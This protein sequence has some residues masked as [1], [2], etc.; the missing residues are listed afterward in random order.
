VGFG[1]RQ[2]WIYYQKSLAWMQES[3][4]GPVQEAP[5]GGAEDL[6]LAGEDLLAIGVGSDGNDGRLW[7]ML[8]RRPSG[9]AA[10]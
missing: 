2:V 9:T 4:F 5:V 3:G 7:R 6:Q 8:A 10:R 1:T